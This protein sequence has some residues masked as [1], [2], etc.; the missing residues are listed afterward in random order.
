MSDPTISGLVKRIEGIVAMNRGGDPM[1]VPRDLLYEI[2]ARLLWELTR[3]TP[4]ENT[5]VR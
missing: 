4:T 2:R 3:P 1:T 5:D